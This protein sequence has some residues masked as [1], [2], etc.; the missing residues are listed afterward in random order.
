MT[1]YSELGPLKPGARV[2][3][4]CPS[5]RPSAERIER[6]VITLSG[7]GLEPVLGA[8][9]GDVHPRAT[10]IGGDDAH[11]AADLQHAWCDDSLEAVLCIRGGYG[12]VRI[13]DLLDACKLGAAKP[14][15]LLGSSDVTALHEYWAEQLGLATWFTPMPATD[16]FLDDPI[17]RA[18]VYEALFTDRAGRVFRHH[19]SEALVTGQGSGVLTG[20]TLSLLTGTLAARGRPNIANHGKIGLLEDVSEDLY[21]LDGMLQS[22]LRAGWFD[23]M[24]GIALGSWDKCGDPAEV[25]ALMKES[26]MPLDI[27]LIWEL[28]FGHGV[29]AHSIPLG[30]PATLYA[31]TSPRLILD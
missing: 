5:G 4:V 28:G 16:A 12:A 9:A 3:L 27:P 22:L 11:R 18:G 25:K 8:H 31:D 2:G 10:Y 23:G 6:A 19:G 24:T 15:M 1:D 26:L 7:W 14:K 21:R 13:L 20:G 29:G 17:A 30:V